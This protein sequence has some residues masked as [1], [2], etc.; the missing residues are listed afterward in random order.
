MNQESYWLELEERYSTQLVIFIAIALVF[1]VL[2]MLEIIEGFL[3]KPTALFA[4][5]FAVSF[6]AVTKRKASKAK[7]IS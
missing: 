7:K 4:L 6:W 1:F 3:Y 2:S 5:I